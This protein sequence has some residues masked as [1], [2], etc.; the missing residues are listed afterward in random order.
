MASALI[1]HFVSARISL[2]LSVAT[3][4]AGLLS[5]PETDTTLVLSA[6]TTA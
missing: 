4:T 5:C 2:I 6:F 1:H 3:A